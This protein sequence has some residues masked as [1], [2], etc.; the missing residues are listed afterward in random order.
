MREKL[1]YYNLG[2]RKYLFLWECLPRI[3]VSRIPE[4]FTGIFT[5]GLAIERFIL[6][7]F[8]FDAATLLCR[9]NR[10]V[11]Y[12]IIL[13]ITT[14]LTS[15]ELIYQYTS[16]LKSPFNCNNIPAGVHGYLAETSE[17]KNRISKKQLREGSFAEHLQ[18]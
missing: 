16:Y 1:D 2:Q 3:L 7:V 15:F 18:T 13:A 12:S 4:L 8:P 9:R 10:L 11:A 14:G 17:Q 5:L 6:I